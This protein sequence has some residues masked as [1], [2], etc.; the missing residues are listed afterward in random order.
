MF[1]VNFE[2]P[3]GPP[4]DEYYEDNYKT[5]IRMKTGKWIRSPDYFIKLPN[6][7]NMSRGGVRGLS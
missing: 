4:V 6:N 5:E 2:I 1:E 7:S 3:Y